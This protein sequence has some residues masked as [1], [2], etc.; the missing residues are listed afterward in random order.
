MET[1]KR[2]T[3]DMTA[4]R[5]GFTLIELLVVIAIIAI[6]AAMLLPA[7]NKAKQAANKTACLGNNKQIG[8]AMRMYGEDYNDAF[9][10]L[11]SSPA[12]SFNQL[13]FLLKDH[14]NLKEGGNAKVA[15][16]PSMKEIPVKSYTFSKVY[17]YNYNGSSTW[18]RP[19]QENGYFHSADPNNWNRQT[20]QSK[21]KYPSFYSS[22]GEP[23][24]ETGGSF[25]FNWNNDSIQGSGP[26]LELNR[27]NP[28]SVYLRGD[29][30]AE[31]MKIYEPQRSSSAYNKYFFPRG[32][33]DWPGI[34]E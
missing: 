8:L 14:L 32:S 18:Y 10:C 2:N 20:K 33:F 7:L 22:V 28:G 4:E 5:S 13:F 25:Y 34:V 11:D 24:R 6:L 12:S 26:K 17:N 9:P 19:N 30:H 1:I 16:C 21:L 23:K 27:H 31:L 3:K 15:V 29:G